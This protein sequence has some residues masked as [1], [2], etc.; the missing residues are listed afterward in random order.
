MPI[1]FVAHHMRESG[2]LPCLRCATT[3]AP[4][5]MPPKRRRWPVG[6]SQ[7]SFQSSVSGAD[8]SHDGERLPSILLGNRGFPRTTSRVGEHPSEISH[9]ETQAHLQA[10]AAFAAAPTLSSD[11]IGIWVVRPSR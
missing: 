9:E 5:L 7:G 8:C 3:R 6:N 10:M 2:L 4:P 11:A 1:S